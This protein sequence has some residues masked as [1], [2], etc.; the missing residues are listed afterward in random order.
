MR[1]AIYTRFS[2]DD[3]S[4][5]SK[6]DSVA[7]QAE[8]ARRAC[9]DKGWDVV[10]VF[11]DDGVSGA[12]I[13]KRAQLQALLS[14]AK[15]GRDFDVVVLRDQDRL[16]RDAL[17]QGV[18]LAQLT[19]AGVK[20]WCY[21][22]G[23]FVE[24]EGFGFLMTTFKGVMAEE[25]RKAIG[26]RVRESM[27]RRLELGQ[28][29]FRAPFGYAI[30]DKKFVIV[31]EQAAIVRFIAMTFAGGGSIRGIANDLNMRGVP[32]PLGVFWD[33]RVVGNILKNPMYR[34]I[35]RFGDRRNVYERGTRKTSRA[36]EADILVVERPELRIIAADLA[37]RI[38]ERLAGHRKPAGAATVRHL[39]SGLLRCSLCGGSMSSRAYGPKR[40][41]DG[42]RHN[43]YA[44]VRNQNSGRAACVG[45]G[46]R[47]ETAV[48]AAILQ[49]VLPLLDG[50]VADRALRNLR[51]KLTAKADGAPD[52]DLGRVRREIA[53][54]ERRRGNLVR[55]IA[56]GDTPT[57]LVEA[58]RKE[59]KRIAQLQGEIERAERVTPARIDVE[60]E[61]RAARNRLGELKAAAQNG[62]ITARPVVEAVL[63]GARFQAVPVQTPAGRRWQITARVGAGYLANVVTQGKPCVAGIEGATELF[64]DDEVVEVDGTAGVVRRISG[65]S[66]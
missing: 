59:E 54:C 39:A 7:V 60:R 63:G 44:C 1:A 62:G 20:V 48:D 37:A 28:A 66:P 61:I 18:L 4:E 50:D 65:A 41:H 24:T 31:E 43:R 30:R 6:T 51:K 36:P 5:R 27:R 13:E 16:A 23:S 53:A 45:I 58:L 49:A 14:A 34:G 47:P 32:S 38:D 3:G 17:R 56:E 26:R 40:G 12:E 55:A 35:L 33:A 64:R 21:A 22:S 8:N 11:E 25:E 52:P 57:A 9:A 19:D 10:R 15:N 29:I 2:L 42:R 46:G